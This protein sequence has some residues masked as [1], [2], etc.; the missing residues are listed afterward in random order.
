MIRHYVVPVFLAACLVLGGASAAGFIAN[1]LLQIAAIPLIG[2]A[3]WQALQASPA[4]SS[5]IPLVMLGLL[6]VLMLLQLVP[7][8]PSLWTLLPG[9]GSVVEGYRLL[10]IPL[11]WLPLS[12]SPHETLASLLWLLPAFAVFLAI[13]LLGAFRGRGIAWA[14]VAVT[15]A[16]IALGALQ[17]IGGQSGGAY[18]YRITNYGQAVGFF[19]NSNHNATLLLVCI[20]FLAAL[21][22]TLLAR[23]KSPRS[24]SAIRLMVGA[25]YAVLLVGLLINSSLAGIGLALPVA[26]TSW[27]LFGRQRPLL[28]RAMIGATL[29]VSLAAIVTIAVGPFGNNLFGQQTENVELSRQTSF[30]LTLKAAHDYFP[31]GSGVGSFQPV[32]R[33]Y[34]PL[35]T[36]TATYMNHAHSDWLEIL[37]ETGLPGMALAGLFL[38]WW[39]L[40]VRAIWSA[41]EPDR[42]AQAAVIASAAILLHSV[43]D[44]PLRTAAISA[45]FAACVALMSGVRPFVKARRTTESSARHLSL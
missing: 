22:A 40:R 30:A 11:P 27:V 5:R 19:A 34:E 43:V 13:T 18:L 17:V 44:Y 35:G 15:L 36:V 1:L 9:R 28:R 3:L 12:L 31:I 39:G 38:V 2:W 23:A 32:Y 20:P 21:Q 29:V 4:P 10:G 45:V 16:S 14:I 41:D 8:P 25:I 7:L 42:F 6:V 26:L 37:L 24:A 33:T